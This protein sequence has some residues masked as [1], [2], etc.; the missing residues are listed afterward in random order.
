MDFDQY[1]S[2]QSSAFFMLSSHKTYL[3]TS[4]SRLSYSRRRYNYL[5]ELNRIRLAN[6]Q[7]WICTTHDNLVPIISDAYLY[8]FELS[9]SVSHAV[10]A[11]KLIA[12]ITTA[13]LASTY[14]ATVDSYITIPFLYFLLLLLFN[15]RLI[16]SFH[17]FD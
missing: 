13:I 6:Q 11:S 3:S 1:P 8:R 7:V 17:Q 14:S 9:C 15:C 12:V 16:Y 5:K 10:S 2:L 4:V